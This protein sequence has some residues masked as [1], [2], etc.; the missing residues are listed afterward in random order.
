M[1]LLTDCV[2]PNKLSVA[3]NGPSVAPNRL[4]VASN[5]LNVTRSNRPSAAPTN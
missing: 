5:K 4:S 3:P 2:A 1:W